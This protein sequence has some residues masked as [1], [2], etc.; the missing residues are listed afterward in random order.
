LKSRHAA[1]VRCN[2]WFAATPNTASGQ[3]NVPLC[4]ALKHLI[5]GGIARNS[6]NLS[7]QLIRKWVA[8]FDVKASHLNGLDTCQIEFLPIPQN[9]K[10]QLRNFRGVGVLVEHTEYSTLAI[11]RTGVRKMITARWQRTIF[12]DERVHDGER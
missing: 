1:A 12:R 4:P 8:L 3:L 9:V 11:I 7:V 5:F 10:Q 6:A 2:G